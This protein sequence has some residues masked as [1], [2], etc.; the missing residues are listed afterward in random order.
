MQ[1]LQ[2]ATIQCPHCREQIEL[3]VD[4]SIRHQE[5][6][7]DCSACYNAITVSVAAVA[8]EIT[9]IKGIAQRKLKHY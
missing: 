5:F 4:C 9:K 7:E 2:T 1:H 8:G 3:R 6:I